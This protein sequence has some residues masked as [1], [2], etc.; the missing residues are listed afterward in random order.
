MP[1]LRE[2]YLSWE[3]LDSDDKSIVESYGKTMTS[4]LELYKPILDALR[5]WDRIQETQG[6]DLF[7]NL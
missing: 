5:Q 3:S 2:L 1:R 7:K 6:I 4:G